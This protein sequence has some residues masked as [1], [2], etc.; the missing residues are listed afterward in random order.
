MEILLPSSLRIN[1]L[2]GAF[3]K[4]VTFVLPPIS[5]SDYIVMVP[6]DAVDVI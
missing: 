5:P 1:V 6:M 4:L 3:I 2:E